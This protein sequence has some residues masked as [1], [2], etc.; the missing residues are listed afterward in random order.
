VGTQATSF[1]YR[2]YGRE[3]IMCQRYLYAISYGGSTY[4]AIASGYAESTTQGRFAIPF[5]VQPRTAPTGLTASSAGHFS[6]FGTTGA[7]ALTSFAFEGGT[8]NSAYIDGNTTAGLV[9]GQ[10][11]VLAITNASAKIYFTGC[12]L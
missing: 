7:Y 2:D 10:G 8:L 11:V 6:I 5:P 12:E 3:L 1:D 9:G 4:A